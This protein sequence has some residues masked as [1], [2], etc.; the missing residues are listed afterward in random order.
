MSR[1]CPQ[2]AESPETDIEIQKLQNGAVDVKITRYEQSSKGILRR[3][4]PEGLHTQKRIYFP[5]R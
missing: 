4:W 3:D 5:K 2:E 1:I